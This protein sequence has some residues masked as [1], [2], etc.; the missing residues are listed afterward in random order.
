M[1]SYHVFIERPRDAG[2]AAAARLAAA[3]ADRY[4]IPAATLTERLA[5]GRLRVKTNVELETAQTFAADLE[6]LGAVCAIIDAATNQPYAP[7]RPKPASA[8]PFSSA[9]SAARADAPAQD[10]GALSSGELSLATL[11]GADDH[12][13]G[14]GFGPPPEAAEALPASMGPPIDMGPPPEVVDAFAPPDAHEMPELALDVDRPKPRVGTTAPPATHPATMNAHAPVDAPPV[15]APRGRGLAGWIRDAR[16]RLAGG[17]VLAILLGFVP[18]AI[19]TSM[20]VGSAFADI[21]ADLA[22]QYRAV[23]DEH[24]WLRLDDARAQ[25][26]S[27]KKEARHDIVLGSMLVWAL[28]G[29]GIAYAWFR[30][31]DWDALAAR[32]R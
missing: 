30:V 9:L 2:A 20:R 14:G 32:V 15:P 13:G 4:G 8:S 12:S 16:L 31:V 24:D 25:A 28:A 29:A 17:V 1:A 26:I 6:A 3:V 22:K 19:I 27:R 23:S 7:P 10:L 21:D 18:A 11:D 5:A